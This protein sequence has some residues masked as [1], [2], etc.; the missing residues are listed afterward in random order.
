MLKYNQTESNC[1]I[2][3]LENIYSLYVLLFCLASSEPS[4][5]TDNIK[6]TLPQLLKRQ[7]TIFVQIC[8]C[9]P[10][11]NLKVK[12]IEMHWRHDLCYIINRESV[13]EKLCHFHCFL[14]YILK[15]NLY[16]LLIWY[17]VLLNFFI[18]LYRFDKWFSFIFFYCNLWLPFIQNK[19]W[20]SKKFFPHR[21][22]V[23]WT[24][25]QL[26]TLTLEKLMS[27]FVGLSN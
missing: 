13:L 8:F 21:S 12:I 1:K 4:S 15:C 26:I 18:V 25:Y 14:K 16:S 10:E 20:K 5:P 7:N 11:L 19:V 24:S 3:L 23:Q 22:F 6:Q 27:W 17:S 9:N 2:I